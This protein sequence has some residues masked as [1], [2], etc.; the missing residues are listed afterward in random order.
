MNS[1]ELFADNRSLFVTVRH[2][3][4]SFVAFY[5]TGHNPP[6]RSNATRGGLERLPTRKPLQVSTVTGSSEGAPRSSGLQ[7]LASLTNN[8]RQASAAAAITSPAS[9]S[10]ADMIA[11]EDDLAACSLRAACQI[12]A[13]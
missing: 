13:S 3:R 1:E 12:D 8:A 6:K 10:G 2:R 9:R 7:G 4:Q 5:W 11:G